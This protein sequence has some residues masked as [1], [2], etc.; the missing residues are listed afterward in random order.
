VVEAHQVAGE[1]GLLA[2]LEQLA[3]RLPAYGARR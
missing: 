1:E 2:M 3:D